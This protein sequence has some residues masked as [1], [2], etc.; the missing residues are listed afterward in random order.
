MYAVGPRQVV[1]DLNDYVKTLLGGVRMKVYTI[2]DAVALEFGPPFVCINDGVAT[3]AFI[4]E[5]MN[6][7]IINSDDYTLFYIGEWDPKTATFKQA[8][9]NV[10]IK[11]S[12]PVGKGGK[13]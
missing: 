3:R 11:I 9:A 4:R 1:L 8:P 2:R 7:D 5:A 13:V 10:P 12:M 6:K